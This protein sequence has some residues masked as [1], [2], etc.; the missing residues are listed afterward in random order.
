MLR[1]AASR[2]FLVMIVVL[3]VPAVARSHAGVHWTVKRAE[4]VLIKHDIRWDDGGKMNVA[5]ARCRGIGHSR[6]GQ[7]GRRLWEEFVCG[8][9]NRSRA[10]ALCVELRP[11]GEGAYR[12]VARAGLTC[13][14]V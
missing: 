1:T 5:F 14:R 8:V 12:V 6:I 2:V 13:P 3:V 10:R 4:Q 7:A 11:V 9:A